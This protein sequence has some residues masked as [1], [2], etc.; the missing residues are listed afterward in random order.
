MILPAPLNHRI[1]VVFPSFRHPPGK[2]RPSRPSAAKSTGQPFC[3]AHCVDTGMTV[4]SPLNA[5]PAPS[6]L[7]GHLHPPPNIFPG[8]SIVDRETS[9]LKQNERAPPLSVAPKLPQ[10]ILIPFTGGMDRW[11]VSP[12]PPPPYPHPGASAVEHAFLFGCAGFLRW[13]FFC[14]HTNRVR[15]SPFSPPG[16]LQYRTVATIV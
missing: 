8:S 9:N 10:R 2:H 14:K 11:G 13:F 4:P 7:R 3:F 6:T 15:A 12:W 1:L 16:L 5:P